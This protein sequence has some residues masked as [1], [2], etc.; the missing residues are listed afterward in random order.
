MSEIAAPIADA[1]SFVSSTAD[2]SPWSLTVYTMAGKK[3]VLSCPQKESTLIRH[4]KQNLFELNDDWPVD[5]QCLMAKMN[6][7][8]KA[9]HESSHEPANK[10]QCLDSHVVVL[11]EGNSVSPQTSSST[12]KND[13]MPVLLQDHSTLDECGLANFSELE[14]LVK[15]IV[16]R[17]TDIVI[18]EKM[19]AGEF[20]DFSNKWNGDEFDTMN[21]TAI[22]HGLKVCSC[23]YDMLMF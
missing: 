23:M 10:R 8:I 13:S 1:A 4:V 20:A 2:E 22:A 18:Q 9:D 14:L 11:N 17:A 16:W 21:F 19:M 5:Q 12:I 3:I 15:I 6:D 7:Q